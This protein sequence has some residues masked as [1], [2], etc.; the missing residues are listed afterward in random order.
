[1]SVKWNE[2]YQKV[3]KQPHRP[4]V[5]RAANL[6]ALN[7]KTAIDA[8]CGTGRD[9]NYLLNQGFTVHAFDAHEDAVET[10]LTRFEGNPCF[11]ISQSCFSDF[12]YPQCSLFIAS[13]SLFFCPSEEFD[14]VWQKID[15]ALMSGGVFCGDLLG[16]KDSWVEAESHPNISAFTKSQ[17]DALFEGYDI[18]HF[19][20]RDEDGTTA[21]GN[22]KHWHMFSITA[23]K[24]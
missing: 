16:V 9:S 5:E 10:C 4:N 20:E 21:V 3:A 24:R 6:L 8:G 11:Y 19:H 2:Y 14:N 22:T 1:M 13:A 15:A 18:I 17:V 23:V 12:H 7:N